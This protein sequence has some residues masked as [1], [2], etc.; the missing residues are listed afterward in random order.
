MVVRAIIVVLII[1]SH[2]KKKTT[3]KVLVELSGPKNL[4]NEILN[5]VY[6]GLQSGTLSNFFHFWTGLY[7]KQDSI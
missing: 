2:V 5:T 4:K 3:T 6:F 7:S 1:H